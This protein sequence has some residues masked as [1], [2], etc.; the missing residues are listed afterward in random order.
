[1]RWM[2][3]KENDWY[4]VKTETIQNAAKQND[5]VILQN[6]WI[7][8]DFLHYFTKL[9]VQTVPL[10]DSSQVKINSEV[11]STI[12]RQGRIFLLPEYKNNIRGLDTHYV[13]SLR[14][15]YAARLKLFREKDPEIWVIE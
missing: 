13:D 14:K 2:Q 1:M 5:L 15:K 8:K 6:G 12:T 10:N 3:H 11:N 7:L 4:Y 9:S